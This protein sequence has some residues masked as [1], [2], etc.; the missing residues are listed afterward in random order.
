MKF[1]QL[2]TNAKKLNVPFTANLLVGEND[3][4]TLTFRLLT[5]Q[6]GMWIY[7]DNM[8]SESSTSFSMKVDHRSACA[9]LVF[10]DDGEEKLS[11]VDII[12]VLYPETELNDPAQAV[13]KSVEDTER[14]AMKV[15][16]TSAMRK[17]SEGVEISEFTL[18][19]KEVVWD[20]LHYGLLRV[21][22]PEFNFSFTNAW[23]EAYRNVRPTPE[24]L[25]L[26]RSI[27]DVQDAVAAVQAKMLADEEEA[28]KAKEARAAEL[29]RAVAEAHAAEAPTE[30]ETPAEVPVETGGN[31][32][33]TAVETGA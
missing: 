2:T 5:G 27:E 9:S 32:V 1:R 23:I 16:W 4:F 13:E 17:S 22:E 21:Y 28:N 26:K 18:G 29:A 15:L 10:L 33:E 14:V 25:R 3:T 8:V 11:P 24:S 30:P 31:N 19:E 7:R 6:E 20:L 12:R